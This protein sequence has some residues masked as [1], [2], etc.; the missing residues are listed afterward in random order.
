VRRALPCCLALLLPAVLAGCRVPVKI[1]F[2]TPTVKPPVVHPP[3]TTFKPPAVHPPRVAHP[4]MRLRPPIIL[5]EEM[6]VRPPASAGK[7]AASHAGKGADKGRS[8]TGEVLKDLGGDAPDLGGLFNDDD[9][10]ERPA[11]GPGPRRKD[12]R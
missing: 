12:K 9:D 1:P 5:P 6:V 7:P 3:T 8:K 2:K 10:K 11:G 4:E